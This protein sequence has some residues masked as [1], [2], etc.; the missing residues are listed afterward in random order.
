MLCAFGLELILHCASPQSYRGTNLH[1][2]KR[3]RNSLRDLLFL[4]LSSLSDELKHAFLV[5]CS[6]RRQSRD[7]HLFLFRRRFDACLR[8][9][10]ENKR[11]R[12]GTPEEGPPSL[13]VLSWLP[14]AGVN[15]SCT[16]ISWP[17]SWGNSVFVSSASAEQWV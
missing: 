13:F 9:V 17:L 11:P 1:D 3:N 2:Q 6:R 7:D 14:L 10:G 5:G 15:S 16:S 8:R 4:D 12:S